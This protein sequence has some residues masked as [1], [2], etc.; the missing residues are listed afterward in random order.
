[1]NS[2]KSTPA[3][4]GPRYPKSQNQVHG[5]QNSKPRGKQ[6][7][8]CPKRKLG[9]TTERGSKTWRF[10]KE[11]SGKSTQSKLKSREICKTTAS[12]VELIK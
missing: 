11:I 3:P 10:D 6:A 4:N 8:K 12:Q 9:I 5:K 1:M 7:N 2:V